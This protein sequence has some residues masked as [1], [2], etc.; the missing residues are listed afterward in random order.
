MSG[1]GRRWHFRHWSLPILAGAGAG[2]VGRLAQ[3]STAGATNN[4]C[5]LYWLVYLYVV[6]NL[7]AATNYLRYSVVTFLTCRQC[8]KVLL[9]LLVAL[10]ASF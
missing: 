3:E 9:V 4:R 2:A 8:K 5:H 6:C 1:C 7:W 10:G